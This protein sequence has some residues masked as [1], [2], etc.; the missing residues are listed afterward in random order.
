[1][2]KSSNA[3]I[4]C[5][6]CGALSPSGRFCTECGAVVRA[7][8]CAA[9]DAILAPGARFCHRCGTPTGATPAAVTSKPALKR[10]TTRRAAPAPQAPKASSRSILPLAIGGIAFIAV[11]V[12]FAAQRAGT[13]ADAAGP[14]TPASPL[15]GAGPVDISQMTPRERAGR[16]FDRVMRYESEGKKDSIAFF[17]SIA[18]GAYEALQPFDADLRYDFGRINQ[19]AGNLDVAQAHADTL[20][21][22]SP[23]HLLGLLLA[24][25]VAEDRGD[26]R[27]RDALE[28]RL[29]AAESA[30]LAKSLEEY[31][32][33]RSEITAAIDAARARKR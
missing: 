9:C 32:L 8:N 33:H 21:R 1:M 10:E 17:A 11:A 4:S 12:I 13:P 26:V 24:A 31:T 16:L 25:L 5:P 2:S 23:T 18:A 6:A 30:E 19:A 29:L 20:L 7:A 22:Q 28:Q 3:P 14:V 15:G 27:Q